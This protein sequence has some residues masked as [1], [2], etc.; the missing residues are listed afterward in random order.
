M[1]AGLP[2]VSWLLLIFS[3]GVPLAIVLT[4][5]FTHRKEKTKGK[6]NP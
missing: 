2:I 6:T 1:I 5:F 3:I 4:F